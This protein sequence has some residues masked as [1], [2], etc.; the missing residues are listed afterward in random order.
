MEGGDVMFVSQVLRGYFQPDAVDRVF[1]QV[2]KFTS[3]VRTDQP[4]DKFLMEFGTF[5]RKAENHMFPTGGGSPDLYFCFLRIRAAQLKP[6]EK[7]LLTAGMAGN[8]EFTRVSKQL[9]Q[10]FQACN[11]APKEDFLH[12][13]R[14]RM[15]ICRMRRGW[16]IGRAINNEREPKML[17]ALPPN[18]LARSANRKNGSK[19]KMASIA[20]LGNGIAVTDVAAN[21]I[22]C[23]NVRRDRRIR[24]RPGRLPLPRFPV[25]PCPPSRW[26]L[27]RRKGNRLN[28]PLP[29]R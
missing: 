24:L 27:P 23:L 10:L 17:R 9:R 28:I 1:T 21:I 3:Y 13:I 12:A 18:R 6:A 26:R 4:I 25:P 16:P 22:F 5:R 7:T 19:K 15:K 20:A 8:I 11:A 2:E 14:R 29:P